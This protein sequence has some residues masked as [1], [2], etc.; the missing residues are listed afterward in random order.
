MRFAWEIEVSTRLL[1]NY[2]LTLLEQW[3][4]QLHAGVDK[5]GFGSIRSDSIKINSNYIWTGSGRVY[6]SS[7]IWVRL[8]SD[9]KLESWKLQNG[10]RVGRKPET[11]VSLWGFGLQ[12]VDWW[13]RQQITDVFSTADGQ[14]CNDRSRKTHS[15]T[16]F[17][18]AAADYGFTWQQQIAASLGNNISRFHL[19]V[20]SSRSRFDSVVNLWSCDSCLLWTC[21]GVCVCESEWL[22]VCAACGA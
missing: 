15:W 13:P 21:A 10:V 9:L 14:T 22:C 2:L 3:K 17:H 4:N 19:A 16:R 8:S 5:T 11:R 18:L 1:T 12:A 20:G 6:N 7:L